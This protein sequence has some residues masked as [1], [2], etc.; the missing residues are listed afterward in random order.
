M[1][2]YNTTVVTLSL[3]F[4]AETACSADERASCDGGNGRSVCAHDSVND[5]FICACPKGYS[6]NQQTYICEGTYYVLYTW[7]RT[8]DTSWVIVCH[9]NMLLSIL[10]EV[11]LTCALNDIVPSCKQ[12]SYIYIYISHICIYIVTT[13]YN[14]MIFAFCSN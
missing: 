8:I 2:K 10:R 12:S 4:T 6:L 7:L 11:T 5:K 13:G 14:S 3:L 9:Q 1:R